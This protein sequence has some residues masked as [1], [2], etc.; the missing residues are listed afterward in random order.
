MLFSLA[1]IVLFA[2]AGAAFVEIVFRGFRLMFFGV[3]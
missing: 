3:R 1:T 2:L